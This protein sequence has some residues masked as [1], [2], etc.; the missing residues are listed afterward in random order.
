MSGGFVQG[1]GFS[2]TSVKPTLFVLV[3][4]FIVEEWLR[5][6]LGAVTPQM[7]MMA[8]FLC[9]LNRGWTPSLMTLFILGLVSGVINGL[10][11]GLQSLLL[12]VMYLLV[13]RVQPAIENQRFTMV[14]VTFSGLLLSIALVENLVLAFLDWPVLSA[15]VFWRWLMS[16]LVGP[17]YIGLGVWLQGKR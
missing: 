10:P 7:T 8:V 11:L 4:S 15:D 2:N 6:I 9:T 3:F 13:L 1:S 17:M 16:A 14:C 5:T 12:V